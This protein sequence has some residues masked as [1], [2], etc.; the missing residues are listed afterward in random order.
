M[1][2]LHTETARFKSPGHKNEFCFFR[3]TLIAIPKC[4]CRRFQSPWLCPL[5]VQPIDKILWLLNLTNGQRHNCVADFDEHINQSRI[6]KSFN[7]WK[8][9]C[10][11]EIYP[12]LFKEWKKRS[13]FCVY[14]CLYPILCCPRTLICRYSLAEFF[15]F[16]CPSTSI[17]WKVFSGGPFCWCL[18]QI[19]EQVN[20]LQFTSGRPFRWCL[21]QLNEQVNLLQK[22]DED[23]FF[24][25]NLS[26]W[27]EDK[28]RNPYSTGLDSVCGGQ[29]LGNQSKIGEIKKLK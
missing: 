20:L 14:V 10:P 26:A 3:D 1:V 13:M 24:L 21:I 2:S 15:V 16:F 22:K 18:I 17:I 12:Y 7:Y 29:S 4:K 27:F 8:R 5:L 6:Y 25:P 19:N 23:H 9:P 28:N 11:S